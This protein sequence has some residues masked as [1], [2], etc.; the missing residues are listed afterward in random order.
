[1]WNNKSDC[2]PNHK[3]ALCKE[4]RKDKSI[5]IRLKLRSNLSADTP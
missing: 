5:K 2:D 1:M 3:K 4:E